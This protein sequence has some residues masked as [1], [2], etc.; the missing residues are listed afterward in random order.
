MNFIKSV[1]DFFR[2]HR[3]VLFITSLVLFIILCYSVGFVTAS[4]GIGIGF[5]ISLVI[6]W[7]VSLI[8]PNIFN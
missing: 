5:I 4:L 2:Y 1:F 7:I 8:D 3:I 6:M